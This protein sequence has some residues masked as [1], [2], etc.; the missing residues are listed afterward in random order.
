LAARGFLGLGAGPRR[1]GVR[2][3]S[4]PRSRC[5]RQVVRFDEYNP[6]R[7]N[8]A[9]IAPGSVQVSASRKIVSLYSPEKRRRLALA[10]TSTSFTSAL[11][12][13][14]SCKALISPSLLA[15]YSKL[16]RGECLTHIGIE[17]TRSMQAAETDD[18]TTCTTRGPRCNRC[19]SPFT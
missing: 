10:S 9:P 4:S 12:T 17:G 18:A 15:L 1:F 6:S 5:A 19:G 16:R 8:R 11:G 3:S 7:L 2:P 14:T 13:A